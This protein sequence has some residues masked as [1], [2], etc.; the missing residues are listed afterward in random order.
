MYEWAALSHET[1]QSGNATCWFADDFDPGRKTLSFVLT[2]RET[3]ARQPFLDRRWS[4]AE[5]PRRTLPIAEAL[6]R[7]PADAPLPTLNFIWHT[8][9][10]C[11]TLIAR[12]LDMPGRNL[13]LCEP[14]ALVPLADAMRVGMLADGRLPAR[15]PE[16][17]LRCLALAGGETVTVKP[18]NFANYLIAEAASRT[19]GKALFLHSDLS[20]FLI[21]VAKRGLSLHKYVRRLFSNIAG[22]SGQPLPWPSHEIFQMSDLEVAA[23]AWHMQIDAFRRQWPQLGGDR[24]ASLDCEAFLAD[25]ETALAK[26]DAFFGLGLGRDHIDRVLAGPLL[27]QHAKLPGYRYDARQR[28]EEKLIARRQL[29]KDLDRVMAWSREAYPTLQTPLPNP[30]MMTGGRARG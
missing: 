20:S 15:T 22:D 23:I 9:Y 11:S 18:S 4:R 24:A 25:P 30:L 13:S 14:L 28:A 16:I 21:S 19:S 10:C 12:A 2:N 29:G 5:R 1:D 17:V 3:L 27:K 6:E 7:V 8:S 26:L